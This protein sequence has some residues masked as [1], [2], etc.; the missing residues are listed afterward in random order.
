MGHRMPSTK[1]PIF[2]KNLMLL[3]LL[4]NLLAISSFAQTIKPSDLVREH[5]DALQRVDMI[6][7]NSNRT[8]Y[9]DFTKLSSYT[10]LDIDLNILTE[11]RTNSPSAVSMKLPLGETETLDLEMVKVD[12]FPDDFTVIEEPS[13]KI[14]DMD[15]GTHY[16]GVI[17]GT[18]NSLVSISMYDNEVAGFVSHPKHQGNF[19]IG[20]MKGNTKKESTHMIYL[21][22]NMKFE[23]G[24]T[25]QTDDQGTSYTR[26]DLEPSASSRAL[27]DC[28]RLLLEV[29]YNMYLELGGTA[30]A[31]NNY[32]NTLFN[33]ISTIYAGEN[34]NTV[35]SQSIFWNSP[36]PY[37]GNDAFSM[38]G[39]YQ[40]NRNNFNADFANLLTNINFGGYA[41]T[42]NGICATENS[43]M[44]VSG[45]INDIQNVPTY[46]FDVQIA[47]H[48]F[49]HLFGSAHTHGC[50]WNG[51]N[52]QID[53]CASVSGNQEG[54]NCYNPNN[55]IIPNNGGTIMSYCYNNP[56]GVNFANGFG[57]QPGNAIRNA[58]SGGSC[59]QACGGN[60]GCSDNELSLL[61]TT[62]QYPGETTWTV[63]N[64]GTTVA[65]G[66]PYNATNTTFSE[67]ICVADGCYTFTINDSYGDG[68]CC[69]YGNGSYTL[70]GP[71][72][73]VIQNGGDFS[74][75]ESTDFCE[76]SGGSSNC[77]EINFNNFNVGSYGG[78]Q[79]QGSSSDLENGNG[80]VLNN[81]AWKSIALNY[82]VTSNT[83]L[84]FEFGSTAQGEIH[85]IGFDNNSGIS[86][87][88]TFQIYGTQNW[89]NRDIDY[90]SIGYWQSFTIPVGSYYTGSF[91]RLF[92]TNDH[93]ESPGDGN[94]YFRS[95][96]IYEGNSCNPSVSNSDIEIATRNGN[97]AMV[98]GLPDEEGESLIS[99]YPNPARDIVNVNIIS[100]I[101]ETSVLQI[102]NIM[103]Q[104]VNQQKVNLVHGDNIYSLSTEELSSGSYFAKLNING[105]NILQKISILK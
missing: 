11:L 93:D 104:L 15:R 99:V 38:L 74:S 92:F 21:D 51:N 54:A 32:M 18:D 26:E 20:R 43:R 67:S 96:K 36:S 44:C 82:T 49:G 91:N 50:Y 30:A 48:E 63:K 5:Q 75:S 105:R 39:S 34:I 23:K 69:A 76:P 88:L 95:I 33:G 42:I 83:V 94:S 29:D 47:T 79:D 58:V 9:S 12:I 57:P 85:G 45:V 6:T 84:E 4:I 13:G 37:S 27:S 72:G 53:D 65:S 24:I 59:L 28:V 8:S 86:S 3:L 89:G 2:M 68:I 41:A 52:T 66:G 22:S 10:M 56:V 62:D 103:G 19:V 31:S 102:F 64:N 78:N 70:T 25:C 55:P 46:S 97:T 73:T 90:S 7:I 80:L 14:I 17:K 16:R 35:F 87:G 81:N 100:S 60:E 98:N 1:P 101:E 61:I 40:A 71:N 77:L